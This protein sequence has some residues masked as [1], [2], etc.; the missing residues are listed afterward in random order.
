MGLW[1]KKVVKI[2]GLLSIQFLIGMTFFITVLIFSTMFLVFYSL[3][4]FDSLNVRD[5]Y[6]QGVEFFNNFY[7]NILDEK[8][9]I[10]LSFYGELERCEGV[11]FDSAT[12]TF[13]KDYLNVI[14]IL[15][16][17][18]IASANILHERYIALFTYWQ[19]NQ[20][21]KRGIYNDT[22][23]FMILRPL[24]IDAKYNT[25]M[26]KGNFYR[27]GDSLTYK[28][29]EYI[30]D[31]IDSEGNMAILKTTHPLCGPN[32]PKFKRSYYFNIYVY[33]YGIIEKY[34]VFIW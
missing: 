12:K 1:R 13:N 27:K 30:V 9:I 23:E 31:Y 25:L 14:N 34:N 17:D 32:T 24:G 11:Y 16:P 10:N 6:F 29:E 5:K 20:T 8:G 4:Y 2:K 19:Y 33:N 21:A 28:G 7:D 18:L 15:N 26:F 22:E 3:K